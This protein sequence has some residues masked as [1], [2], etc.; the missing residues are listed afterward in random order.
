MSSDLCQGIFHVCF[1]LFMFTFPVIAKA[2][3]GLSEAN[4]ILASA[5]AIELLEFRLLNTLFEYQFCYIL[6]KSFE[7]L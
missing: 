4:G 2:H 6:L 3:F 1:Q 5:D 7:H